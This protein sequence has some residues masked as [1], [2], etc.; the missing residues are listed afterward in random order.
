MTAF[1]TGLLIGAFIGGAVGVITLALCVAA[2][3]PQYP[4]REDD[5]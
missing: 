1:W 2:R 5:F 3:G 4:M